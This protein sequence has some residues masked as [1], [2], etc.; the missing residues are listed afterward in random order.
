MTT[1]CQLLQGAAA[2][3]SSKTAVLMQRGY[4]IERWSY[5]YLWEFSERL[6]TY[7]R[8]KG[9]QHGDRLLWPES[10]MALSNT[11][12]KIRCSRRLWK[13]I[14]LGRRWGL[15]R[16]HQSYHLSPRNN[17]GVFILLH[18]LRRQ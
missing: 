6:A 18:Q 2:D 11:N 12:G 9:L 1:L 7:L 14:S 15:P 3:F 10:H 5:Q 8:G 16:L 4:R 17:Q 13:I